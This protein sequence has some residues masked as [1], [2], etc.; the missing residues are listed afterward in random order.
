MVDVAGKKG[1]G[2]I[3]GR[4]IARKEVALKRAIHRKK[5][6]SESRGPKEENRENREN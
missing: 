5:E 3:N 4:E 2:E 6:S 1:V